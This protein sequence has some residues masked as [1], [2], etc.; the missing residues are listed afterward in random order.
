MFKLDKTFAIRIGGVLL[1][2]AL[3][4]TTAMA[5]GTGGGAGGGSGPS[6]AGS[7]VIPIARGV[8]ICQGEGV[9]LSRPT[10]GRIIA[11]VCAGIAH[12]YGWKSNTVR[13]VALLSCLLPGPQFLIY[14]VLWIL[15]PSD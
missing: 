9:K 6:G 10:S 15:I 2:L 4:A 12:R 5:Q 1:G 13:I 8:T 3:S 11:G 7:G 14:I